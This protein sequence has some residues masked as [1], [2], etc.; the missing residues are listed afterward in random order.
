MDIIDTISK[1]F[2]VSKSGQEN[3][4]VHIYKNVLQDNSI[5]TRYWLYHV[6]LKFYKKKTRSRKHQRKLQN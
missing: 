1:L 2:W 6:E 3:I 5:H 4:Q